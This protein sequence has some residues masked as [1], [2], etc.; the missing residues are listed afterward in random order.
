MSSPRAK[1]PLP[2]IY[3]DA[4]SSKSGY[5]IMN[6]RGIYINI[7]EASAKRH[8]KTHGYAST[9]EHGMPQSPVDEALVEI[10]RKQDLDYAGA[11][12]GYRSGHYDI[13]GRRVLVTKSPKLVEPKEGSYSLL[14]SVFG[15]MLYEPQFNQISYFFG[16]LR[17]WLESLYAQQ[18]APGQ[19]LV[20]AGPIDTCKSLT[21]SILTVLS[22][23][24]SAKCYQF[25]TDRTNFNSELFQAEHLVVEDD[26]E[27][28]DIRARRHFGADIKGIAV[29][30]DHMC[31]PKG[32]TALTLTPRWRLSIS[33]NDEP[34]RM[35]VLPPMDPDIADKIIMLRTARVQLPFSIETTQ[36]KEKF[37]GRLIS[38]LPAF[39][40]FILRYEIPDGLRSSRFGVTHF[41]HPQ[42]SRALTEFTPETQML[43][44]LDRLLQERG[45]TSLTMSAFDLENAIRSNADSR[46]E[47]ER[48]F[49]FSSA[50]GVYLQRLSVKHPQRVTSAPG[51]SKWTIKSG[52]A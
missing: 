43:S 11:L 41:H 19:A 52:A 3:Y 42:L 18:W 36:Q 30:R 47:A 37:W 8:L 24:R 33:L 51:R 20:L 7:N 10:Q 31:H 46:F 26:A 23:G 28:I 2:E 12:A 9:L 1:L 21:Q 13:N 35:M 49:R 4:S 22:G 14:L 25:M 39:V 50:C 44:L 32:R 34:E 48:L 40:H 15:Q 6:D 17:V 27:S 5:W 16:W 29:N 38:E 45:Q